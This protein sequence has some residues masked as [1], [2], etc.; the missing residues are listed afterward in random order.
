MTSGSAIDRTSLLQRLAIASLKSTIARIIFALEADIAAVDALRWPRLAIL[1]L[2]AAKAVV[3]E[4]IIC[5]KWIEILAKKV[6]IESFL[7]VWSGI[8]FRAVRDVREYR[9]QKR[10]HRHVTVSRHSPH[11]TEYSHRVLR[12][13]CENQKNK[14]NLTY[15]QFE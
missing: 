6:L 7:V 11:S 13:I 15:L 3:H 2:L 5:N 12:M 8:E 1:V 4:R 9:Q 14:T 10:R